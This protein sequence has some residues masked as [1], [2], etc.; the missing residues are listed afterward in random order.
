M[1]IGASTTMRRELCTQLTGL[2]IS[3]EMLEEA[4]N[5]GRIQILGPVIPR[6]EEPG[7]MNIDDV[8]NALEKAHLNIDE[9]QRV[10]VGLELSPLVISLGMDNLLS[11]LSRILSI[12]QNYGSVVSGIIQTGLMREQAMAQVRSLAD[13]IVRIWMHGDFNYLQVIKT[14]NSV[15]TRVQAIMETPEPPYLKIIT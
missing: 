1:Q 12:S 15:R 11:L 2:G 3:Q 9:T 7:A 4:S 6:G 5:S 8:I 10:R 14:V 13:G